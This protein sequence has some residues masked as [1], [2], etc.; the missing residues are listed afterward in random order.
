MLVYNYHS[1]F[2]LK[3]SYINCQGGSFSNITNAPN[4]D[5][6]IV[7]N[8]KFNLSCINDHTSYWFLVPNQGKIEFSDCSIDLNN[9]GLNFRL[10]QTS[11]LNGEVI[12]SSNTVNFISN[13]SGGSI[14]GNYIL[15]CWNDNCSITIK[16]NNI[17]ANNLCNLAF[18]ISK[19]IS[20]Y[21]I[22]ISKNKF[23]DFLSKG[24]LF[25]NIGIMED[26]VTY[27]DNEQL[28]SN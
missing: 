4:E 17:Y 27:L 21:T 12:F 5:T 28:Y 19:E 23:Y 7:D 8:C 15:N 3:D 13:N 16:D 24:S 2:T 10:I 14:Y 22:D 26:K 1:L 11:A 20:H 18:T 9:V 6:I 25:T